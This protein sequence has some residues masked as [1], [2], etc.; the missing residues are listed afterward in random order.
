MKKVT[1]WTHT[2]DIYKLAQKQG[3]FSQFYKLKDEHVLPPKIK[4]IKVFGPPDLLLIFNQLFVSV[5]GGS[6]KQIG[7]TLKNV[8]KEGSGHNI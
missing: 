6:K 2:I 1:C 5:N 7:K 8:V 4:K 3:P